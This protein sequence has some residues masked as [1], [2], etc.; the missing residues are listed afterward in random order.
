MLA[1]RQR[2]THG[3]LQNSRDSRRLTGPRMVRAFFVAYL[4]I[5]SALPQACPCTV[6]CFTESL[7]DAPLNSVKSELSER[8]CGTCPCA[9]DSRC[10]ASCVGIEREDDEPANNCPCPDSGRHSAA[11]AI[12][13]RTDVSGSL[14]DIVQSN[15][16]STWQPSVESGLACGAISNIEFVGLNRPAAKQRLQLLC[17]LRC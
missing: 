7:P 11:P 15:V 6:G 13:V 2:H 4:T 14:S 12:S 3:F 9:R 16:R 8:G 17:S 10:S 1:R 5:L